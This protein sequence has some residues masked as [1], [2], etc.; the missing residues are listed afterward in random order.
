METVKKNEFLG[1]TVLNLLWYLPEGH[2]TQ[3]LTDMGTEVI[4]VEDTARGGF[5]RYDEPG[6]NGV[7]YYFVTLGRNR[8]GLL[9]SSKPDE[10][11]EIFYRLIRR[12]NVTLEGFRP[13]VTNRLGV[14][15]QQI[16]E[17][18]SD[19]IYCLL[20]GY[21]QFRPSGLKALYG[22]SVQ[23]QSGYLSL[24]G[25]RVSPLYLCD[26]VSGTV[27]VRAALAALYQRNVS[28][29]GDY[30]DVPIF[31][32][33]VWWSNIL[34]NRCCLYG[35]QLEAKDLEY[36]TVCHNICDISDDGEVA[37]GMAGR[38]PGRSFAALRVR[39]G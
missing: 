21:G 34:D 32:S 12:A 17:V 25:G 30:I 28:D 15:Y 19:I 20:S 36:P 9:V 6:V 1:L 38:D 10:G 2:A 7:G 24:N 33:F 11:K 39:R 3:V 18:K 22:I 27:A 37:V 16:R 23:T 31:G 8:K 29:R 4:R 5:C 14:E 35:Y 13:R 26:L